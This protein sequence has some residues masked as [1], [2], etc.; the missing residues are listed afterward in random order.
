MGVSMPCQELFLEQSDEY[1]RSVLSGN[2]PTLSVEAGVV[3]GW[4]RFSHAQIGMSRFGASAP[5][6]KLLEKFGFTT[7]NV[8]SKAKEL[9]EFYKKA[10]SV[11]DLMNRPLFRSTN[12][13]H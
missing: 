1:Q 13:A 10:G 11:P 9:I 7:E 5:Y 2:V 8:T 12:G 3:D 6:K 4:Y